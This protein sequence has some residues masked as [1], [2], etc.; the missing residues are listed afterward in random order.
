MS[1][2]PNE[3]SSLEQRVNEAIAVYLEAVDR[4]EIPSRDKFLADHRDVAAELQ[5]FFADQAAF[6]S[7]QQAAVRLKAVLR[8]TGTP[9]NEPMLTRQQHGVPSSKG[10]ICNF[11]DYELLEEIARGG[12]GVVF[13][14]RQMTL[15]RVVA[16]KMI[17]AGS[18]AGQEDVERF[19]TEAEAAAKLDH[20]G[21]VP[22]HDVGQHDG[23]HYF[24]M[25][26]VEGKSL[27]T[28][29]AQGPLPVREA[30]E[31]VKTVAEAVQYAHG[32]GVIHRDLKPGN[33]LL[34]QEGKPRV[35][36]FGLA[37][38]TESGSD[39]TGTGQV[40]GT[41][42]YMP[43]E[44]AAGQ[45]SAVGRQSDVYSLGAI[46]Y[47]LLTGR[48]PFQAATP[49]ETLLQ[50]QK[51][52]P[53]APKNL[54][55]GIP[56]DLNTIALKCLEKDPARRYQS[57]Q[58]VAQELQRFLNGVPIVARPISTVERSWRWC[59][60][61]PLIP[62]VVAALLV[63]SSIAGLVVH[64]SAENGRQQ[65]L[66]SQV[67][68]A[69]DV[70]QSNRGLAVPVGLK[71]LQDLP[72]GL[73]V[74]ELRS[75]DELAVQ[76]HKPGLA[77]ARAAFGDVDVEFL[78]SQVKDATLDEVDNLAAALGHARDAALT[79]IAA[80]AQ[81]AH[82]VADW[83]HKVRLAVLALHLG[84][85]RLAADMCQIENRPD[86]IQRAI[87]I[88]EFPNWHGGLERLAAQAQSQSESALRSGLALGVGG[89]P[90]KRLTERSAWQTVLN[91]WF[92]EQPDSATHSAADWALRQ[93]NVDLPVLANSSRPLDSR[94]WFVNSLGMT[95]VKVRAGQFVR[96]E[97]VQ[98]PNDQSIRQPHQMVTLR[99]FYLCDRE[100]TKAHFQEFMN[101]PQCPPKDKPANFNRGDNLDMRE[102]PQAFV[103]WYDAVLFCNWLSRRE[104][105]APCYKRTGRQER[106][107][108]TEYDEWRL[109]AHATG[110]RLPTEA[111]WEYASRAGATK[112]FTCG[113]AQELLPKYAVLQASRAE[114][115]GGKL[116]NAWGL[117]D[118]HGNLWEWCYDW[119]A[120]YGAGDV[121]DPVGASPGSASRIHR[122]GGWD[123]NPFHCQSASRSWA[124]P[125]S[126]GSNIG[127]RVARNAAAAPAQDVTDGDSHGFE[128]SPPE[129]AD[130]TRPP[131]VAELERVGSAS[132]QAA[133][134]EATH[135]AR[136][137]TNGNFAAGLE[138][139]RVEG[140][141][142]ACG[143]YT[144]GSEVGLTTY[145]TKKESCTC[146]LAQSFKVPDDGRELRFWLH[147]GSNRKKIF[148][149]L[150]R[151][152]R[153][154]RLATGRE[155]NT[156][157]RVRW[158]VTPL[159]GEVV[160]FEIVDESTGPWGFIGVQDLA[161]ATNPRT[162]LS[163]MELTYVDREGRIVSR[164]FSDDES[165]FIPCPTGVPRW[166]QW[167]ERDRRLLVLVGN[168]LIRLP[169]DGIGDR[170]ILWTFNAEPANQLSVTLD[171]KRV[172]WL[173]REEGK[174]GYC[175][176]VQNFGE[177]QQLNLGPGCDPIWTCDGSLLIFVTGELGWKLKTWDGATINAC[178]HPIHPSGGSLPAPSPDGKLIA[179]GAGA[180]NETRQ[181][182]L[183]NI[184]G[185]HF[186]K[187]THNTRDNSNPAFSP[188][189]RY[190]AY[191]RTVS[192]VFELA[193]VD[194]E[195]EEEIILAD[196]AAGSRPT[197]R[198]IPDRSDGK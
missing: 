90:A 12:M 35:T 18:L 96:G 54:N 107:G 94:D 16:V 127:F 174:P 138:G 61:R 17:L 145:G 86:P 5:S 160:T 190:V 117:F 21:I 171:E 80:L 156:P 167:S 72:R 85:H 4:G 74:A 108:N 88:D 142:G 114:R 98:D 181:I 50:V 30:A 170:E 139:W 122:G 131:T 34:D 105:L 8:T 25:G 64:H 182:A 84:D 55:P 149:A 89:I 121:S 111:E 93:W 195:T 69:L 103:N 151:G 104:G 15:N 79:K 188:D 109:P 133:V 128:N 31:I 51:L 11:G 144:I 95:L 67:G 177:K 53:V 43:P 197:W 178:T 126:R 82:E 165:R 10:V 40:L 129:D 130:A 153:L 100:V 179:F 62:S 155:D 192:N 106:F 70:V 101:D 120:A 166:I 132:E 172:V 28:R 161:L 6:D 14:A 19:H 173:Q 102:H 52:E 66:R 118:M 57:A 44:Q 186:R 20:P 123:C 162:T 135:A 125:D 39:L 185:T 63:I 168:Q 141:S 26:F 75:R 33:I 164:R 59:K 1:S 180:D 48:P 113:S 49:L 73:V 189:G 157:F 83:R 7:G 115:A 193:Y 76:K 119:A 78:C 60:R 42:S 147:G 41:P 146:R 194:L 23:Q 92:R 187:V 87:F 191:L 112:E 183:I 77:Y 27:A 148:V 38:L 159:S 196:D 124:P 150:W 136:P 143:V 22:I 68:T 134:E 65:N 116:P 163:P 46:L 24:S 140:E 175:V 45:V 152:N 3:P 184:D 91:D 58:V 36:D 37:K 47:C 32:K 9:T 29:V 2:T 169:D 198:R 81:Q 56:L 137:L 99:A 71:K 176:T 110:Y 97:I 13:K 158:D 154:Y